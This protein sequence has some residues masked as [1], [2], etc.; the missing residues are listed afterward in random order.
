M[1]SVPPMGWK[2]SSSRAAT[3]VSQK[4]CT[5]RTATACEENSSGLSTQSATAIRKVARSQNQRKLAGP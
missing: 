5:S 2:P 1:Y 4:I 3:S